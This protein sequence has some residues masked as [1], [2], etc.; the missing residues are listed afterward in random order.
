MTLLTFKTRGFLLYTPAAPQPYSCWGYPICA[1]CAA[2]KMTVEYQHRAMLKSFEAPAPSLALS[3]TV[4]PPSL[5]SSIYKNGL[6]CKG[7][8]CVCRDG[9][10]EMGE[11]KRGSPTLKQL[12]SNWWRIYFA[13]LVYFAEQTTLAK[14]WLQ[15]IIFDWKETLADMHDCVAVGAMGF[16]LAQGE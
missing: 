9:E 4:K 2:D 12:A 8:I 13:I 11:L 10:N 16:V 15:T 5:S 3:R 1:A 7:K 14:Q 6:F